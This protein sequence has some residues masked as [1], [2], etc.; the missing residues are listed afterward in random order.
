M[1]MV[2][3]STTTISP[4]RVGSQRGYKTICVKKRVERHL[5]T[6]LPIEER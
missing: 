4:T 1:E 2:E 6:D 3:M 5:S